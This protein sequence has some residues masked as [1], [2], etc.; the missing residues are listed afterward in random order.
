M[1]NFTRSATELTNVK[2]KGRQV[3][4]VASRVSAVCIVA[5]SSNQVRVLTR[6]RHCRKSRGLKIV[7]NHTAHFRRQSY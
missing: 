1:R 2:G 4:P 3:R 5:P 7:E 6:S